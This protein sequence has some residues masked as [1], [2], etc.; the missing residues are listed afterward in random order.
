[1]SDFYPPEDA[2]LPDDWPRREA[3][4]E[5]SE[6]P[7][8]VIFTEMMRREARKRTP[9]PEEKAPL[10]DFSPFWEDTTSPHPA[11][12]TPPPE[13]T[14]TEAAHQA[15]HRRESPTT[16]ALTAQRI[17]RI[18]RRRERRRHRTVG[19]IGGFIRTLLV[20]I[21]AAGLASTIFTYFTDPS[22]IGERVVQSL[23]IADATSQATLQPT[24]LPS[25]PNWLKVIGV[26]SGHRGPQNDPG[27]VCPD[28]L[29]EAE[30]NFNVAQRVV[31]R[32]RQ[33]GY[34]AELLDEFD[35]R[36][37]NYQAA[38]LVSIHANTCQD[39]GEYVS[40]YL[41]AK[42]A[43]RPEGGLDSV[44]AEC[45]AGY[46]ERATQLQR[47]FSLTVDMTNYH[48]FREIHPLTPAAI[49]ELGFMKDDREL[50]TNQPDLL[51]QGVTEGILCFLQ[52]EL[53][54]P[55]AQPTPEG[56]S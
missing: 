44:L 48:T 34:D 49:I 2:P 35:P 38:A 15:S 11:E 22:F 32:L 4:A 30:I 31:S 40:G 7:A 9:L 5:P 41:V 16:D 33:L 36:L 18:Q 54:P 52:P 55:I 51:A 12:R 13:H 1:M 27:A 3:D 8:S 24:S 23:Q 10:E 37:D 21:L 46:Y 19:T 39:F 29:T 26:V 6:I 53:Y 56:T 42:A 14:D 45:I 28:G 20:C 25:T 50:L 17:R 47:R 43:A